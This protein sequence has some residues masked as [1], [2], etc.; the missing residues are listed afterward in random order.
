MDHYERG[1]RIRFQPNDCPLCGARHDPVVL[2][3][4]K[5]YRWISE[6]ENIQNVFPEM[7]AA[8]REILISG[9]CAECWKDLFQRCAKEDLEL[10]NT[11]RSE[12]PTTASEA[13]KAQREAMDKFTGAM[14]IERMR[15]EKLWNQRE[16]EQMAKDFAQME[17]EEEASRMALL[18]EQSE[19]YD[20]NDFQSYCQ[21]PIDGSTF[22]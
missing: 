19:Y 6:Q 14:E 9:T 18:E 16:L 22:F 2:D 4:N 1:E 12:V 8:E 7:S 10:E 21:D 11:D 5:Y 3:A 15:K 20:E 17:L 13:E